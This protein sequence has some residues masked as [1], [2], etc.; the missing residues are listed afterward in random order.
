MVYDPDSAKHQRALTEMRLEQKSNKEALDRQQKERHFEERQAKIDE[1]TAIKKRAVEQ[2]YQIAQDR[3]D[4]KERYEASKV[5]IAELQAQM[6]PEIMRIGHELQLKI[7]EAEEQAWINRENVLEQG[8]K[9]ECE[10]EEKRLILLHKQAEEMAKITLKADLEIAREQAKLQDSEAL[11][12]SAIFLYRHCP[13]PTPENTS[14]EFERWSGSLC[15]EGAT[16]SPDHD[17]KGMFP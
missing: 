2:Q 7:L 12:A 16:G 4:A 9:Y 11:I 3:Q 13:V 10:R 15:P 8:K 6:Q 1:A 17:E 5:Y 14:D